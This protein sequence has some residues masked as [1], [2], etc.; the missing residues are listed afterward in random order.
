[1]VKH[2]NGPD[3]TCRI[4]IQSKI[5]FPCD[6]KQSNS[7]IA[8]NNVWNKQVIHILREE[9]EGNFIVKVNLISRLPKSVDLSHER[10]LTNFKYQE[11]ASY[12]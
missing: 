5:K 4:Q 10:F 6:T 12:A 2:F 9:H 11:P 8:I 3:Q 1:M 7:K